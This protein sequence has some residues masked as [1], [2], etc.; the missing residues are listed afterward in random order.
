MSSRS[1]T[2]LSGYAKQNRGF[3]RR[4][5]GLPCMSESQTRAYLI[6]RDLLRRIQ[7]TSCGILP[8]EDVA[9][10]RRVRSVSTQ[11]WAR[12]GVGGNPAVR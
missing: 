6:A 7:R 8:P 10:N 2:A 3:G 11:S 5:A 9:K 12:S 4:R 1:D